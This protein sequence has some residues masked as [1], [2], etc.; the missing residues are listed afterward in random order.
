[1]R[2]GERGSFRQDDKRSAIPSRRSISARTK[3]PPSE[4]SRPPIECKLNRLAHDGGQ[5]RQKRGILRHGGGE[6]R[7]IVMKR[8]QH[9]NHT[10]YQRVASPP[11]AQ[12]SGVMNFCG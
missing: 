10:R 6:L 7:C 11:P 4:V 2:S 9:Q 5:T 12:H 1:M 3:T 8:L